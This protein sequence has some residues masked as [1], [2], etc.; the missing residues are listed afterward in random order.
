MDIYNK[1]FLVIG[2][3][4]SGYATTEFLLS[5]GAKVTLTDIKPIEQLNIN[6]LINKRNFRG[7]FGPS[8]L[9][10]YWKK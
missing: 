1:D 10:Q 9:Y 5:K 3:G 7:I 2:T 6:N 8:P 4:L